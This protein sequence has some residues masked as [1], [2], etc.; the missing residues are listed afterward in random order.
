[1]T[2]DFSPMPAG[3]VNLLAA[4]QVRD[5]TPPQISPSDLIGAA[6]LGSEQSLGSFTMLATSYPI[7][8]SAA[9]EVSFK[10]V[11]FLVTTVSFVVSS[12][13]TGHPT[14]SAVAE[15]C[16]LTL[17][18][19][20]T[21]Y[22][23]SAKFLLSNSRCVNASV[24]STDAQDYSVTTKQCASRTADGNL[25]FFLILDVQTDFP[26]GMILPRPYEPSVEVATK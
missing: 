17:T 25:Q 22:T 2:S 1:M 15:S 6:P 23:V 13:A 18:S 9:G 26:R 14:M 4:R 5:T 19:L 12:S 10:L 3:L 8:R 20:V 7:V 16:P 11:T 24:Y 21:F